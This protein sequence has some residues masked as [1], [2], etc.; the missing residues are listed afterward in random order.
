MRWQKS[1]GTI[2]PPG[3]FIPLAEK[4]GFIS[5]LDENM[6]Y[7][8]CRC[9]RELLDSGIKPPPV[10]VNMSRQLLYD[11][12][13]IEKYMGTMQRFSLPV[14]LIELEIT[15]TALFENQDKFVHIIQKLHDNGFRILMDDFGTGYSSLMMLKS[16]PIDI[17][18][19]DKTFIDEYDSEEDV[20]IIKC[21]TDL[22]KSLKISVI[23]EGVEIEE[24]YKL[25]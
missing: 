12:Q 18:K 5:Q 7:M 24:Q 15:E 4:N 9:Q 21:V 3:E 8:V 16:I 19:L 11:N 23:A 13:F 6:F 1:D 25:L 20:N 10:S 22:A 17:M 2:V 14:D